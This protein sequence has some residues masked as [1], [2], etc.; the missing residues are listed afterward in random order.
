MLLSKVLYLSDRQSCAS[1]NVGS[2][3]AHTFHIGSRLEQSFSF[4]FGF[5]LG[6]P[7]CFSL[8][9]SFDATFLFG[10]VENIVLDHNHVQML[11][12]RMSLA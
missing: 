4:A 12:I 9:Q 6:K 1:C 10:G 7:L 3:Y 5:A 2:R 11:V 8:C